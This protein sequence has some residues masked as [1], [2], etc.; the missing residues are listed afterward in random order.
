MRKTGY[1]LRKKTKRK[2]WLPVDP[3]AHAIAGAAI[4]DRKSLDQLRL[5]EL[6]ALEAMVKGKGVTADWSA[7]VDCLNICETMARNGIGPE[8][9]ESCEIA[10]DSL[11]KCALHHEKTGRMVLDGVGIQAIRDM[12]EYADLQQTSISRSEFE[13]MIIKTKNYIAA[14]KNVVAIE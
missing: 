2:I 9:L 7:L 10:Q 4:T 8:A 12:I 14:G 13:K 5:R 11:H 1:Q 6:S 3:I